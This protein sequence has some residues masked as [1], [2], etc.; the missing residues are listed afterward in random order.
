MARSP[1]TV[2]PQSQPK[3]KKGQKCPEAIKVKN[4]HKKVHDQKSMVGTIGPQIH[5]LRH[6]QGQWGQDPPLLRPLEEFQSGQ[7]APVHNGVYQHILIRHQILSRRGL[8]HSFWDTAQRP[9]L[10]MKERTESKKE[11][12]FEVGSTYSS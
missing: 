6:F 1:W 9:C 10:G 11:A 5:I 4:H 7:E 3:T 12:Y 8:W 2:G